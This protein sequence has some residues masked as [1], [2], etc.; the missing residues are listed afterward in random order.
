MTKGDWAFGAGIVL[1]GLA[2]ILLPSAQFVGFAQPIQSGTYEGQTID[3]SHQRGFI[4][5]TN[6]LTTKTHE[7]SSEREDWCVPDNRPELVDKVR[8]IGD[9][10][11][12]RITYHRPLW[13]WIDHCQPG[14]KV[15]DSIERMN[16]TA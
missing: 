9:G 12:V 14:L 11:E 13:I 1:L 3:Y 10:E 8:S 16:E 2:L 7:R 6:D 4:F 5:K 15:I